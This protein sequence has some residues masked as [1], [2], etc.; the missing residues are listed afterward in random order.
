MADTPPGP[1]IP[2]PHGLAK[3][4]N[5]GRAWRY[6]AVALSAVALLLAG[7]LVYVATHSPVTLVPYGM[8]L[9]HG[10]VKVNPGGHTN[11]AYLAYVAQADL[12]LILNWTPN[13]VQSQVER[14]L[15]RLTPDAYA[16]EQTALLAAA[17]LDKRN[18]IT[19]TFFPKHL[20]YYGNTVQVTGLLVRYAG[21]IQVSSQPVTYSLKYTFM[22]G[23]PYVSVIEKA[24]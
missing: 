2:Y 9:A 23:T 19:E 13:T 8:S 14:F 7:G 6:T 1:H 22:Q 17:K 10:P 15:N 18:D 12:G 24:Q 11:G 21:S 20:Q 16:K 3:A 5:E 4:F